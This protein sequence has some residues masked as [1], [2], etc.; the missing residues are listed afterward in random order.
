MPV[1]KVTEEERIIQIM[2]KLDPLLHR[3]LRN[4]IDESATI[5]LSVAANMI[6]T[7]NTIAILIVERSGGDV[8]SFMHNLMEM[9]RDKVHYAKATGK[10][11]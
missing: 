1:Q 2:E 11:H 7:L 3:Y 9:T 8:D 6:T 4:R 5:G 10:S